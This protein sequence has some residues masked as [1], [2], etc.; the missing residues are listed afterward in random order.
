MLMQPSETSSADAAQPHATGFVQGFCGAFENAAFKEPY[1]GFSQLVDKVS[2]TNILPQPEIVQAHADNTSASAGQ[3][4]GNMVGSA[5]PFIAMYRMVGSGA[6]S[7]LEMTNKF[8]MTMEALPVLGKSAATGAA[9]GTLFQ[10]VNDQN[11]WT[12]KLA[13]A[14]STAAASV[15]MTGGYI[16]LKG[17]GVGALQNDAVIGVATGLPAGIAGVNIDSLINSGTLASPTDD[18]KA[19]L[20]MA[21]ASGIM[22]G[23][24]LLHEHF[25][26]TTGI[27]GIRGLADLTASNDAAVKV[28]GDPNPFYHVISEVD[29]PHDIKDLLDG[30]IQFLPPASRDVISHG[31]ADLTASHEAIKGT[32]PRAVIY[33][34]ARLPEDSFEYQR[35]RRLSRQL[36]EMGYTIVNGGGPGGME[37]ASRGAFEGGGTAVGVRVNLPFEEKPNKYIDIATLHKDVFTRMEALT[38]LP[39]VYIV[40]RSGWGTDAEAMYALGLMQLRHIDQRPFYMLDVDHATALDRVWRQQAK[41]KLI[42]PRDLNFYKITNNT[43]LIADE[44]RAYKPQLDQQYAQHRIDNEPYLAQALPRRQTVARVS[45]SNGNFN[46]SDFIAAKPDKFSGLSVHPTDLSA[47]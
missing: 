7:K 16:G 12:G 25:K 38:K 3:W 22:G 20:S 11:F 24:N 36:S 35:I 29:S 18:L 28:S 4:L 10:P 27:P 19:G 33:A 5:L 17:L 21:A 42:S 1:A 44:L 13:A 30:N 32:G 14:T 9:Y 34:S 15:I 40:A 2:G 41:D 43:D 8:G 37:A 6:S 45:G 23:A 26:P 47:N 31:A 39:D 46:F